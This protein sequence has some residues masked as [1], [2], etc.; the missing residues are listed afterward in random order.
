M[1]A[2]EFYWFDKTE[3]A[4]FI[5]LQ[6]ERREDISRITR[7]A[8]LNLGRKIVG[9]KADVAHIYFIQVEVR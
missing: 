3:E 4:H 7:E 6:Q 1:L 8:V 5:G 9:D 2:Y